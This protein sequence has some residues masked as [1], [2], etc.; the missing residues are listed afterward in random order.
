[1]EGEGEGEDEGEGEG[2]GEEEQDKDK[3][4]VLG[5][6][7]QLSC[8][9]DGDAST[10]PGKGISLTLGGYWGAPGSGHTWPE[11]GHTLGG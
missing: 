8:N 9:P 3:E 10:R 1:M 6:P 4:K 2:E 5:K 7:F 11:P